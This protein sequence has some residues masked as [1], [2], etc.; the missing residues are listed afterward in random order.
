[1]E[2]GQGPNWGCSAKGKEVL[3][4]KLIINQIVNKVTAFIG[5]QRFIAVLKIAGHWTLSSAR[6]IQSIP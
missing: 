1:M 2:V 3:L 4:K 5:T 6:S